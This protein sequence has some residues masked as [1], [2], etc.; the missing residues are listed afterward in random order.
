MSDI[1]YCLGIWFPVRNK[2]MHGK[3]TVILDRKI[4][5]RDQEFRRSRVLNQELIRVT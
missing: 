4:Q 3:R 5:S 1:D 2:A